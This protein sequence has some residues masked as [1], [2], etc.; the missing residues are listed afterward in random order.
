[1][2]ILRLNLLPTE[3]KTKF[4]STVR[5]LFAKEMLEY[6][7][8][9][10]AVLAIA[11]LLGWFILTETLTNLA[12]ASLLTSREFPGVNQDVRRINALTKELALASDGYVQLTPRLVEIAGALPPEIRLTAVSLDRGTGTLVVSGVAKTRAA[13]L[14]YETTVKGY[15][16]VEK[17]TSPTSQLFQKENINFELKAHLNIIP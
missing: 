16:W 14:T 10:C 13:L 9:T 5:F 3:K 4:A 8:F 1:M 17:V 6:V 12:A 15:P 11:N 2:M 7:I